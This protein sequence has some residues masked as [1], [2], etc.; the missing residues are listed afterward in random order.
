MDASDKVLLP[1]KEVPEDANTGTKLCAF[2]YMDSQ[3]RMIATLREPVLEL[4]G[5]AVLKVADVGRIGAFLD[6]GLEKD[7]L[8]PF[9]QQT[10]KVR[11][12][13]SC[14]VALYQDKSGRLCA[15]MNVYEYLSTDSH[16]ARMT[17]CREPS[18]RPAVNSECLWQWTTGTPV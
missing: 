11:P 18:T 16:T 14:L 13:E 7:L 6:W 9:K 15:T 5:L 4:G 12:G 8:L 3:D 10:R 2:L 1:K 17:G